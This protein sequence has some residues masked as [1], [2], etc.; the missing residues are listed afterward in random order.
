[1]AIG[2][3]T[4]DTIDRLHPGDR[5]LFLWDTELHGFGL[6]VTPSGKK[7]YIVQY[8]LGGRG[9]PTRRVTL[10][11]HGAL[12]PDQARRQAKQALGKV[13]AGID[14]AEERQ[15]AKREHLATATVK[16]MAED[17]L[18]M[19]VRGKLKASSAKEYERLVSKLIIWYLVTEGSRT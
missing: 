13:A 17:F 19:H 5:D 4:K 7:V 9:S 3:I 11:V 12:T 14:V 15:R 6:K 2:K 1:M 18:E 8:Q 10:G 16:A